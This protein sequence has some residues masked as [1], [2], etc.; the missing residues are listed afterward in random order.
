M[1][2]TIDGPAGAGKS[3]VARALAER[4]GLH[5]LDTGSM[6]RAVAFAVREAAV[7]P[8]D[9]DAVAALLPTLEFHFGAGVT[10]LAGRDIA[11][12][13][14]TPEITRLSSLLAK[15]RRVRQFLVP[16]QRQ[17]GEKHGLVTEG[18]DQ[19]TVVFPDAGVKF[20]VTA[21]R[22]ERARRRLKDLLA[23]G[24]ALTLDEVLAAQDE[25]DRQDTE[26]H[27]G[28]LRAAPDAH[29]IDTT[30]LSLAEVLARMVQ[31]VSQ[32]GFPCTGLPTNLPP[33]S[34]P[35]P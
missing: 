32:I 27:D 3:T 4:L 8:A 21:D 15:Q 24:E 17:I 5:F 14:R 1:I 18:R 11:A 19:G 25:R 20:F 30:G 22:V 34:S 35:S 28:P 33:S 9:E 26:R 29:T 23:K 6:Y 7:D 16:L 13:I 10:Q 31:T 12:I 2:V